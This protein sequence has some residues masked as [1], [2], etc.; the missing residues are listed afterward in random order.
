MS[1]S[2]PPLAPPKNPNAQANHV[3][4]P[5]QSSH[6]IKKLKSDVPKPNPDKGKGVANPSKSSK[7]SSRSVSSRLHLKDNFSQ[8][9]SEIHPQGFDQPK[10]STKR[11]KEGSS[12]KRSNVS[13]SEYGF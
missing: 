4:S 3:V 2:L 11:S 8:V 7:D 5:M 1:L 13:H 6:A 10:A 12:E 9:I